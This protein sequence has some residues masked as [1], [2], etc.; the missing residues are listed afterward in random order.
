ML[1]LLIGPDYIDK[2]TRARVAASLRDLQDVLQCQDTTTGTCTLRFI[3][4]KGDGP[5]TGRGRSWTGEKGTVSTKT[6][7]RRKEI[8]STKLRNAIHKK[9]GTQLRE[10]LNAMALSPEILWWHAP[11]WLKNVRGGRR[12]YVRFLSPAQTGAEM[13]EKGGSNPR[14]R[15]ASVAFPPDDGEAEGE[16]R[17]RRAVSV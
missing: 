11:M 1:T 2:L 14:K 12:G 4:Y 16:E 8:S 9:T 17:Q 5:T 3:K 10:T 7:R 15:R 13:E 6:S